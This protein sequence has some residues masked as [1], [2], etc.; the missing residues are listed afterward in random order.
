MVSAFLGA[1][2]TCQCF[3]YRM[4]TPPRLEPGAAAIAVRSIYQRHRDRGDQYLGEMGSTPADVRFY[5]RRNAGRLP[6]GLLA[7]DLPDVA[8]L[9]LD[10]W[11]HG[12]EEERFW[13][14]VV[15]RLGA[16]R[17]EFAR[18]AA[19]IT[20]RQGFRDWSD[21][22]H[23]L[24]DETG[25]GRPDEQAARA[26]RAEAAAAA[27]GGDE[28]WLRANLRRYVSL[29]YRVARLYP[30][31]GEEAADDVL[32]VVRDVRRPETFGAAAVVALG[33][34]V[35]A[36]QEDG[37]EELADEVEGIVQAWNQLEQSRRSAR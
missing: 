11:W 14:D 33:W 37:G 5:L 12:R 21:R 30:R 20:S 35:E 13:T 23:E 29:A 2:A 27:A 34:A 18:A 17:A 16:D 26:R 32:E 3:A 1:V 28:G 8:V 31:V 24:L 19:G 22:L 25:S 6:D 9:L 15:I 36:L 7:D 4:A 10:Q